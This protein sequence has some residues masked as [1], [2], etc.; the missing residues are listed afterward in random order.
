MMKRR[1]ENDEILI[2]VVELCENEL[3]KVTGGS[4]SSAKPHVSEIVITKRF[5]KASTNLFM[6]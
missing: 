6:N 5:D 3:N 4:R 1:S 2:P